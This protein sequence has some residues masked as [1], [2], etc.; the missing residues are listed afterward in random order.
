MPSHRTDGDRM[1]FASSHPL[2]EIGD[3]PAFHASA[4]QGDAVRRFNE[5]PLQIVVHI[6]GG[7]TVP[8]LPP[9]GMHSRCGAGVGGQVRGARKPGDVTD[10]VSNDNAQNRSNT[11]YRTQ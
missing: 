1:T 7:V 3:M 8:D 6:R 2:V 5:C 4:N 9:L 11:G 10:F